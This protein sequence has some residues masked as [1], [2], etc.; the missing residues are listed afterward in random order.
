MDNVNL[1]VGCFNVGPKRHQHSH[2]NT[3]AST[4]MVL[5]CFSFTALMASAAPPP[6]PP[7][8]TQATIAFSS[9]AALQVSVG[10][11]DDFATTVLGDAWDMDHA[12]D[13]QY[14]IGFTG[15]QN[16]NGIWQAVT[17]GR[18]DISG[19]T[20]GAYVLPLFHGF[21]GELPWHKWGMNPQYA[22]QPAK[23]NLLSYRVAVDV[24]S[25]ASNMYWNNEAAWPTGAIGKTNSD[26]CA[27]TATRWAIRTADLSS[28]PSWVG[29]DRIRSLRIDPYLT[30]PPSDTLIKFD[31]I[32]LVDPLSSPRVPI[33]WTVGAAPGGSVVDVYVSPSAS[34][35]EATRLVAGLP[36]AAA[37]HALMSAMLPAGTWYV[38]LR[39]A[40]PGTGCGTLLASSAWA[41]PINILPRPRVE[42]S[43]PSFDSGEDYAS[44]EIG[45]PWDMS[46]SADLVA[47]NSPGGPQP[48]VADT[49]FSNG[50][51]SGRSIINPQIST[52]ESDAQV[53]PRLDSSQGIDT[54]RYRY[55]TVRI[56]LGEPVPSKDINWKIATG[57]GGRLTWW[58]DG[59]IEN[60]SQTKFGAYYEGW[61]TY[62]LDLGKAVQS[63]SP[64][65]D[66]PLYYPAGALPQA[67]WSSIG[68]V[69]VLRYDLIET[70]NAA[71]NT[72][73]ARFEVDY[74]KLTAMDEV[75]SGQ[76]FALGFVSSVSARQTEI[77]F[78]TDPINAPTQNTVKIATIPPPL[79]NPRRTFLPGISGPAV[80]NPPVG[81]GALWDTTG[82]APGVYHIC[83]RLSD[84]ANLP[85]LSC[86]Q[87]PVRVLP[88]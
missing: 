69:K 16:A 1:W 65:F 47:V 23:Y 30:A 19:N 51:F 37:S 11:G 54:T 52:V 29:Q 18:D 41:G 59:V 80:T 44:R 7:G 2:M 58:R 66:N 10:E 13:I 81:P 83:F 9:P 26:T 61:N 27:D 33:S 56:K 14:E 20:T 50:I 78:T 3:T 63:T 38:Q 46:N 73:A 22:I 12:R 15:K 34:G 4:V 75:R 77:F 88:G 36:P 84:G 70:T 76:R 17:S 67:G 35:A 85:M 45:D 24:A 72:N 21:Q 87:T 6:A 55:F 8:R 57:W 79:N 86:S 49:T 5:A 39:L 43:R 32:R 28:T 60:G 71:I 64:A 68:R 25:A 82:V 74:F 42:I 53:W 40:T 48:T 62:R 31:W